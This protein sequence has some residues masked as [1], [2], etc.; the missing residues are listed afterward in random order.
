MSHMTFYISIYTVPHCEHVKRRE[1]ERERAEDESLVCSWR[2]ANPPGWF[3]KDLLQRPALL[4]WPWWLMGQNWISCDC[5]GKGGRR[6]GDDGGGG[7]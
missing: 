3:G 6:G 1:R 2:S 5:E 7:A 4:T